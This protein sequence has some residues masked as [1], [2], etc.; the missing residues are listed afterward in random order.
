MGATAAS[1]RPLQRGHA[2]DLTS[3]ATL[4]ADP[5]SRLWLGTHDGLNAADFPNLRADSC[6]IFAHLDI[7]TGIMTVLPHK[8]FAA[9]AG[10]LLAVM[11]L[12]V[13]VQAGRFQ[14]QTITGF[15]KT[16]SSQTFGEGLATYYT[17]HVRPLKTRKPGAATSFIRADALPTYPAAGRCSDHQRDCDRD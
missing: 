12:A 15:T 16:D 10:L 8:V 1:K 17:Y 7:A 11:L 3:S 14:Q 5:N 4:S 13:Q 2:E 9:Q 6:H